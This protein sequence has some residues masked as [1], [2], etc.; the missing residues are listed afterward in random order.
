MKHPAPL[1]LIDPFGQDR[2]AAARLG[3]F[4]RRDDC[5]AYS[6]CL[7]R[8]A[9]EDWRGFSCAA[10]EAYNEDP[11]S[12]LC[13]VPTT[14]LVVGHVALVED[15]DAD[16]WLSM[17]GRMPEEPRIPVVTA[18]AWATRYGPRHRV[19]NPHWSHYQTGD[20]VLCAPVGRGSC[21]DCAVSY[22]GQRTTFVLRDGYCPVCRRFIDATEDGFEMVED[23]ASR[24]CLELLR[25]EKAAQERRQGSL[26]D[27]GPK[28][29]RLLRVAQAAARGLS[30]GID[31]AIEAGEQLGLWEEL[32]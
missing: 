19:L 21:P 29:P 17:V 10:C 16:H 31:E 8:A 15:A 23:V 6:L 4:H 2:W 27:T 14:A 32:P 18:E 11:L 12:F 28:P 30:R 24:R 25:A 5:G 7:W 3:D 13:L 22:H 9:V 26:F 20:T 1:P